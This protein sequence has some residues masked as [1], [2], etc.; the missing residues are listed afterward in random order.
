M[1]PDS[2]PISLEAQGGSL[3][4]C[5]VS[6]AVA[7]RFAYGGKRTYSRDADKLACAVHA[8]L[9]IPHL[10]REEGTFELSIFAEA[11]HDMLQRDFGEVILPALY[12]ER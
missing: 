7:R 3:S 5:A 4:R 9:P 10:C 11:V 6:A 8:L 1:L 2:F 12:E